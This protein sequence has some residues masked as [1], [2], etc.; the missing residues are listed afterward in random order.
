M[1]PNTLT[2]S[3][4]QTTSSNAKSVPSTNGNM[5]D[6]IMK[7]TEKQKSNNFKKK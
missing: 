5:L 4:K 3:V 7:N 1:K 6:S 2:T